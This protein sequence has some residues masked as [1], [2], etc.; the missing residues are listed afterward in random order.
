MSR[1]IAEIRDDIEFTRGQLRDTAEAI[2]WK[3]D[4]PAR[5]RD[6]MRETAAVVRERVASGSTAPPA[7]GDSP[8][9]ADRIG[10]AVSA[11]SNRAGAAKD[12]VAGG[13]RSLKDA[14]GS[15][16]HAVGEQASAARE[17]VSGQVEGARE[18]ARGL[19]DN[20]PSTRPAVADAA[21]FARRNPMG[22]ALGALAVGI[23]AGVLIPSSRAEREQV[24]PVADDLR[25]R[26]EQ[27][28]RQAMERGREAAEDLTEAVSPS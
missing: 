22:V 13:A 5:A 17:A 1:D 18:G 28:G 4:V 8:S 9:M 23:A 7:H 16:A 19:S 11:V 26:G 12:T 25:E 3:A 21:G 6:I 14:A 2:G 20:L 27:L 15:G 24:A 10:A